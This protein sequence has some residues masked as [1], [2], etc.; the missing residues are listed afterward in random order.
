MPFPFT[1]LSPPQQP[2][3]TKRRSS[4]SENGLPDGENSKTSHSTSSVDS[5]EYKIRNE[6]PTPSPSLFGRLVSL[7]R[8]TSAEDHDDFVVADC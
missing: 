4:A 5:M 7:V 1:L 6:D 3:E 8:F 2:D